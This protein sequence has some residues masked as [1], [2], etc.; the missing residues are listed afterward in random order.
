M[1]LMVPLIALFIF[2]GLTQQTLSR[3]IYVRTIMAILVVALVFYFRS[4]Y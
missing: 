3:K 1:S 2:I 4:P